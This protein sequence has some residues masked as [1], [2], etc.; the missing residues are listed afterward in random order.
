MVRRRFLFGLV[1]CAWISASCGGDDDGSDG[2]AASVASCNAQCDAQEEV[3]GSGCE[4][5]VDLTTCKQLCEQLAKSVGSCGSQF[6]AYYDCS[7]ADGFMCLGSL[8]VNKTKDCEDE[9]SALNSCKNGGGASCEGANPNGTCPQV[10]CPC[11]EGTKMVS[12]FD[13]DSGGCAC[14]D[15]N[16]CKD[17]FCD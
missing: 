12:G 7:A 11:P 1:V 9:L 14:L 2:T 8:V 16:T 15:S 3:R 6:D 4:P 17:L 5:F 13:N 10:A